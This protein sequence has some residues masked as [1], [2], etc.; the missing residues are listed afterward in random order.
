MII[1]VMLSLLFLLLA[2]FGLSADAH[3][4]HSKDDPVSIPSRPHIYYCRSPNME[5][6]TCWWHPLEDGSHGDDVTYNFTYIIGYK[7]PVQECPDYVTGGPNSCYFDAAHTLIWEVYCMNVTAK[8]RSGRVTSQEHCLDVAEIVEIDPPFNLTHVLMNVSENESG[9][10]VLVS[11]SYPI[12]SH[13]HTGWI[14]LVYELRYRLISEPSKWKVKGLLREPHLELL[15]LPVGTYEV[16]VRC[17]SKNNNIWSQLSTP[18][19]FTVP[20]THSP[21]RM[22]ALILMTGVGIMVF[23]IIGFGII[24]QGKR[25]K[26]LLLPPIPNP[27][28]RGIDPMLLKKGKMDEINRHFSTFHGYKPPQYIEETWCQ[29]SAAGVLSVQSSPQ[30]HSMEEDTRSPQTESQHLLQTSLASSPYSHVL[31]PYV[32]SPPG[33]SADSITQSSAWPWPSTGNLPQPE[34]VSFPGMDYSMILNPTSQ[35]TPTF[36]PP[37]AQDFYTC[38]NRVSTSGAVHLVPCVPEAGR[39]PAYLQ[40]VEQESDKS[41][42]L[43]ANLVKK[44]EAL[45][46]GSGDVS[47][48]ETKK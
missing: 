45:T 10:T 8:S 1:R 47:Q 42:Q 24:P 48:E 34:L 37:T 38:V 31:S 4:I 35:A 18:L 32:D 43:S 11:W 30:S 6:F 33:A 3:N 27:R 39:S 7:P 20:P 2:C 14:T 40:M 29:V 41:S 46:N 28:I 17:R 26:A 19:I 12:Q 25:I 9:R 13:V 44:T 36:C 5:T 16:M 22:M 15:D 21:D 23:L